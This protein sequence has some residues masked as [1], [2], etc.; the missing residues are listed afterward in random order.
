MKNNNIIT[1]PLDNYT[2]RIRCFKR[3]LNK[4]MQRKRRHNTSFSTD[5]YKYININTVI[6]QYPE[7][8]T[9]VALLIGRLE[10]RLAFFRHDS[11]RVVR[12]KLMRARW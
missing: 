6:T 9:N 7:I 11:L 5:V 4:R 1:T 10:N 2:E 3:D 8:E 12:E